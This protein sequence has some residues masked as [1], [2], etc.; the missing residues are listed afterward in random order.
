MSWT[1]I[2]Q[3]D[4][5]EG[6]PL[7]ERIDA[8]FEQQ[9]D[10]WP[11]LRDG[12]AALGSLQRKTLS[13]DGE[14]VV[15]QVNP[16]R[17]RSTHAKTDAA[18]VSA[19]P[20]FLCPQNMPAEERGVTSEDLVVLPNP[21]PVL[22]LHTTVA[23]REHRPQKIEGE[24]GKLLRLAMEVGPEM[25]AFYNGP[26]CGASAPDHLHFQAASADAM[27]ILSQIPSLPNGISAHESFGRKML[28]CS[29]ADESELATEV[30]EIIRALQ[31]VERVSEEPMVNMVAIY[32]GGRY[33]VILF[34]RAAH[35]PAC[36]FQTGPQ[37]LAVSPAVLEM[38]GI[39][40]TTEVDDFDRMDAATARAI[41]G[42]VSI[43]GERFERLKSEL[44]LS[45]SR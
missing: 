33:L 41:Y 25:A 10:T 13:A 6:V 43:S 9:R 16:A 32:R 12:E 30:K 19:R 22:P 5:G 34:P 39:L 26:R 1:Q 27:P 38:C 17:R 23:A 8:L 18:A 45:N 42:E 3:N 31:H 21:F 44:N 35:R 4:P 28:I 15:V 37:K 14:T 2:L 20:C 40:V 36:Y 24:V 7:R 29:G 11:A